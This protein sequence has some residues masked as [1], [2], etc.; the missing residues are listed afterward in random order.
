LNRD[1]IFLAARENTGTNPVGAQNGQNTLKIYQYNQPLKTSFPMRLAGK[2]SSLPDSQQGNSRE[3]KKE[4]RLGLV[5][6]LLHSL[7]FDRDRKMARFGPRRKSGW[8]GYSIAPMDFT[9]RHA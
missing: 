6:I 1:R 9:S 3:R 7:R 5:P 2:K 4:G 8:P